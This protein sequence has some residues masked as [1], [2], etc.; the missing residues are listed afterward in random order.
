MK[1]IPTTLRAAAAALV[2]AVA[3]C[4]VG[5]DGPPRATVPLS[6]TNEPAT[7]KLAV[8]TPDKWWTLYSD[9][10]LN[11]A[12]EEA[13][14]HN[15]DLRVAA[16]NLLAAMAMQDEVD[17]RGRLHAATGAWAG[18]GNATSGQPEAA[19]AD[20]GEGHTGS[21][22]GASLDVGWE[23]DLFG[24]LRH[25]ADA[26]RE[27][28]QSA[29]AARDG[30]RILVAADTTRAWLQA[31]STASRLAIQQHSIRLLEDGLALAHRLRD[32]GAG[33][34]LDVAR[35]R[36]LIAE[37]RADAANLAAARR[38]ALARLAVLMGRVPEDA[39]AQA[40]TCEAPPALSGAMLANDPV[41]ML[42]RRP[43]LRE[44]EHE[45]AA[46]T[47]RLG[48]ARAELYPR[49]ALGGGITHAVLD[50]GRGGESRSTVWSLGPLLSWSFPDMTA[51]RARIAQAGAH[52]SAAL[53]RFDGAI[54]RALG[55][56]RQSLIAYDAA[57]RRVA[58]LTQAERQSD[59][60]LRLA[61]LGRQAGETSALEYLDAQ[62][63]DV[64]TQA[65]LAGARAALI[66]A[67]VQVFKAAGGGWREAPAVALAV[68][69]RVAAAGPSI[70]K[71][72][73]G[74]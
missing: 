48:V 11:D 73:I 32:T 60:A 15:R 3:G 7:T 25:L 21:R 45:L 61:T 40:R 59:E 47:A 42:R 53:A 5:P 55:E 67:Q 8:D 49:I 1:I 4:A 12:V 10:A 20:A 58:D 38:Q 56:L 41:A 13:L 24:R 9:D 74:Q 63:Q 57:S 6:P 71:G 35:A 28:T 26:A 46:A 51:A 37:T 50:V 62:R 30:V 31:C 23:L 54:L 36:A 14:T 66:D 18:H 52:E 69:D 2:L 16:A 39:P 72:E 33:S 27:D 43:D 64:A 29:A 34:A 22:V 44:A 19:M 65:R 68:P 17:D 70:G